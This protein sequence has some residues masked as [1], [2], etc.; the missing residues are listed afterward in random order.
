MQYITMQ[1]LLHDVTD[2]VLRREAL[3]GP[4]AS[5]LFAMEDETI[6]NL[7]TGSWSRQRKG[8]TRLGILL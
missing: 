1:A 5:L 2:I 4:A 8:G 7:A 6:R 3:G